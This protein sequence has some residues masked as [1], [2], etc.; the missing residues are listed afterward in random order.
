M[1]LCY[2]RLSG[3]TGPVYGRIV[4]SDVADLL[5]VSPYDIIQQDLSSNLDVQAH[6]FCQIVCRFY[7]RVTDFD[8]NY[9]N[10]FGGS[11][12]RFKFGG[13]TMQNADCNYPIEFLTYT[14][15]TSKRYV[16]LITELEKPVDPVFEDC[17][18]VDSTSRL[19]GVTTPYPSYATHDYVTDI[20]IQPAET[21]TMDVLCVYSGNVNI[22]AD[23]FTSEDIIYLNF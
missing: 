17:V 19:I 12:A 18:A 20:I 16:S 23:Q 3:S 2:A 14:Q 5:A 22:N 13:Y 21:V 15:Q 8:P 4:V 10:Q 9:I 11:L 1:T 6:W 7:F